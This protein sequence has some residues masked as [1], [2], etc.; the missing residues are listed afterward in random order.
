[1]SSV[2]PEWPLPLRRHLREAAW[3]GRLPLLA[4]E[5][6]HSLLDTLR[7]GLRYAVAPW[8]LWLG[9]SLAFYV[10]AK[11]GALVL[12]VG[13]LLGVALGSAP[14]AVACRYGL[15]PVDA[16]RATL[17]QR[18]AQPLVLAT[19]LSQIGWTGVVL[20]L[21]GRGGAHL[22]GA[23]GLGPSA[24]A[25]STLSLIGLVAIYSLVRLETEL[26]RLLYKIAIPG[27][28]LIAG[29]I[30]NSFLAH[31]A[32]LKL[33]LQSP[34]GHFNEP[35]LPKLLAIECAL[36]YGLAFLPGRMRIVRHAQNERAAL[37]ASLA[38]W[39]LVAAAAA[40]LGLWEGLLYQ[41]LDATLWLTTLGGRFFG[42]TALAVFAAG[43]LGVGTTLMRN[44]RLTLHHL[45]SLRRQ[46]QTTL[47]GWIFVPLGLVLLLP[48]HPVSPRQLV[49]GAA[50]RLWRAFGDGVEP[51]SVGH[52]P[53]A[54]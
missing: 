14:A 54:P 38:T 43:T 20:M 45:R 27:L 12:F 42:A 24:L 21:F 3:S 11:H 7:R 31:D 41:S 36:G 30:G 29:L 26:P 17:G 8:S 37:Y 51:R 50:R 33:W 39:G 18:G 46:P 9:S 1:M 49:C 22:L 53:P 28:V 5:R 48:A 44:C 32:W 40:T 16:C 6:G 13:C 35:N 52:A 4:D 2:P 23:L 10:D 47:T 19:L 15:D 34:F 25:A